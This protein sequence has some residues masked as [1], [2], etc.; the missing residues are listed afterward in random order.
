MNATDSRDVFNMDQ[1][2]E[3]DVESIMQE[4][5]SVATV[6]IGSKFPSMPA[7]AQDAQAGERMGRQ[8]SVS[9]RDA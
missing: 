7:D 6:A 3:E 8:M 4:A 2:Y 5:A 9:N 1:S